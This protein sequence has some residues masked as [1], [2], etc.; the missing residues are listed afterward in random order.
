MARARAGARGGEGCMKVTT[1]SSLKDIIVVTS[2]LINKVL[3]SYR[4]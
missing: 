3:I 1:L 2:S 4:I